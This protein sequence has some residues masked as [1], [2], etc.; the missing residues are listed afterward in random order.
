VR[1]LVIEDEVRMADV[2]RAGLRGHGFDVRVVGTAAEGIE[3]A[4]LAAWTVIVLDINLPDDD[5]FSVCR[6]LRAA[7]IATPILMLT[8]RDSVD[9]RV[10]GLEVGA[11]D[12][13]VKPFALRELAARMWALARRPPSVA[14]AVLRVADLELNVRTRA[15]R[16]GDVVIELTAKEL[17]LLELFMRNRGA[18]LDRAAITAHVWD[19]NHDP[20]TNAVEVLVR[21]L[22]A[23]IDE[24]FSP[25]L[26]HTVRGI[27]Y[28]LGA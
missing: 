11:D 26:V 15:V 21:R 9:D 3:Q 4:V 1:V 24:P 28:R 14:D 2:L 13:L 23:K 5:G 19:S 6:R 10:T 17:A 16:R 12:Y 7:G 8:A 18:V 25:R 20:F 22:R 27:G